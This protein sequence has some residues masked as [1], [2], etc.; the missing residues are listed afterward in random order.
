MTIGQ[1]GQEI[2]LTIG[3]IP[4]VPVRLR[5]GWTLRPQ[6]WYL[7]PNADEVVG[8]TI[9]PFTPSGSI[10][11]EVIVSWPEGS[12]EAWSRASFEVHHGPDQNDIWIVKTAESD[13]YDATAAAGAAT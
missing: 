6:T 4:V 9:M 12:H 10:G 5:V 13:S 11:F 1:Q 2:P 3:T 7:T 8:R